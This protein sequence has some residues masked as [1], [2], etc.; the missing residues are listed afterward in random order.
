MRY[1]DFGIFLMLPD[2]ELK[3]ESE[4]GM[5]PRDNVVFEAGLFTGKLSQSHAIVV[6]AED[7]NLSCRLISRA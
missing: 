7:R 6:A 4:V 3:R 5:A 1:Y 2:D